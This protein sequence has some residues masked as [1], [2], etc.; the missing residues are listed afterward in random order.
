MYFVHQQGL[1]LE[2]RR[3]VGANG[4]NAFFVTARTLFRFRFTLAELHFGVELWGRAERGAQCCLSAAL[5]FFLAVLIVR[6]D[7][8]AS[9]RKFNAA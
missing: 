6:P 5:R 3:R 9:G 2:G 1:G 8:Q 4:V 7:I